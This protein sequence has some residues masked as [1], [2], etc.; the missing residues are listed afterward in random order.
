VFYSRPESITSSFLN[1]V[2][3]HNILRFN[4]SLP[5]HYSPLKSRPRKASL[6]RPKKRLSK[7]LLRLR[8]KSSSKSR[9]P[10]KPKSLTYGYDKLNTWAIWLMSI[11]NRFRRL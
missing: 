6:K 2:T 3:N 5:E 1:K 10:T 9:R 8:K 11:K 7:Y 4:L